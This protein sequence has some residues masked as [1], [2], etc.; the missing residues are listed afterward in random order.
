VA[1]GVR[2]ARKSV[3][4]F[5]GHRHADLLARSDRSTDRLLAATDLLIAGPYERDRPTRHPLLSSAN[6]Q[7][8]H[9]SDRYRGYDFSSTLRKTELRISTDGTLTTTGFPSTPVDP[10]AT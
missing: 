8:V 4:I 7:L 5:T 9:L 6:Q 2:A 1:E 3:V 10:N